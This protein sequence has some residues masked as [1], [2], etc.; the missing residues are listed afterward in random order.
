MVL[1]EKFVLMFIFLLM[2]TE[3]FPQLMELLHSL[4]IWHKAKKLNK[5]LHQVSSANSFED[6]Q[7]FQFPS[8]NYIASK[9]G[10]TG[11]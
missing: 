1:A 6:A 3:K 7:R 8:F 5:A 9:T 2:L 11:H 10:H 4:D